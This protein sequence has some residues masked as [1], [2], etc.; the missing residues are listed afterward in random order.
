MGHAVGRMAYAALA[1]FATKGRAAFEGLDLANGILTG[2]TNDSHDSAYQRFGSVVV[3]D[4]DHG[5]LLAIAAVAV[6]EFA[7]SPLARFHLQGDLVGPG[8]ENEILVMPIQKRVLGRMD[9]SFDEGR[10]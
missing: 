7:P 10:S 9:E 1:F 4:H 6:L 5:N 3:S 8:V 2:A